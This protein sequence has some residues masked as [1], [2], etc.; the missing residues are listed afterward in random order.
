MT[1]A[2]SAEHATFRISHSRWP[3]LALTGVW[4]VLVVVGLAQNLSMPDAQARIWMLDLDTERSVYT[5]FSQALFLGAAVLLLLVG[6]DER[7][8]RSRLAVHWFLLAALFCYLSLDEAISIHEKL[9]VPTS[10]LLGTSGALAFA[11]V[12]PY[13]LAAV[14]GLMLA[15]SFLRALPRSTLIQFMVAAAVFLGGA[16]C[17]EMVGSYLEPA[18]PTQTRSLGYWLA[19]TLEEALEG[20]GLIIFIDALFVHLRRARPAR[21]HLLTT[22]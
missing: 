10:R 11:W 5:W 1:A 17:M 16:L 9:S 18:D 12:I 21:H 8:A 3:A 7:R 14:V 4:A 2:S 19:T 20:L 13:G 22:V 15:T 6:L